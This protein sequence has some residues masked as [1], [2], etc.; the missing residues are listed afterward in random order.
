MTDDD[1]LDPTEA[2]FVARWRLE[3][4]AY[5]ALPE[6]TPE[7]ELVIAIQE[8]WARTMVWSWRQ[9]GDVPKSRTDDDLSAIALR[10]IRGYPMETRAERLI[11]TIESHP[12]PTRW[13]RIKDLLHLPGKR[14]GAP[15]EM[16]Q[17]FADRL[18]QRI[19][20]GKPWPPEPPADD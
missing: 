18:R 13:D 8:A 12:P 1:D 11:R 2:E 19:D 14:T 4:A 16:T 9:R 15:K 3:S 6:D 10:A 5:F 17:H 20:Q 7:E